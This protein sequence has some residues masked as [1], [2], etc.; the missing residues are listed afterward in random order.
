MKRDTFGEHHSFMCSIY[1]S[2]PEWD[3]ER[4]RKKLKK[5]YEEYEIRRRMCKFY[6]EYVYDKDGNCKTIMHPNPDYDPNY[7]E[8]LQAKKQEEEAL[9]LKKTLKLPEIERNS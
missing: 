8:K 6:Y 2:I 7:A 3:H 4:V 1:D 9:S 5:K